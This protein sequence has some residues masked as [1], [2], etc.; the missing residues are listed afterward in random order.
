ME[1]VLW[2]V[3]AVGC[4]FLKKGI[5][6]KCHSVSGL[7]CVTSGFVLCLNVLFRMK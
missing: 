2:T 3:V 5:E 4:V 6:S 1:R 7:N